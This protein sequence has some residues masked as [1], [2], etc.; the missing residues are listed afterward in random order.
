[1]LMSTSSN[2]TAPPPPKKKEKEKPIGCM[3]KLTNQKNKGWK[4]NELE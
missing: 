3:C 4:E 1:M 2:G